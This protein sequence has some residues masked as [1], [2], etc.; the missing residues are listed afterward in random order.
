VIT[1]VLTLESLVSLAVFFAKI[2]LNLSTLMLVFLVDLAQLFLV[3]R[4]SSLSTVSPVQ[5]LLS[6][7]LLP[8][9]SPHRFVVLVIKT[10]V[11]F[12]VL[13]LKRTVL[14]PV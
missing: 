7:T 9:Q 1:I 5:F 8:V 12:F 2:A 6:F 3:P 4:I 10:I 11:L 14:L 13:T